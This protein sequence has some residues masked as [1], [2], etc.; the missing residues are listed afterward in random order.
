MG[1]VLSTKGR[2]VSRGIVSDKLLTGPVSDIMTTH[3]VYISPDATARAA[4]DLMLEER[5]GSLLVMAEDGLVAGVV[6][7][8]D[9]V[10]EGLHVGDAWVEASEDDGWAP[11]RWRS[12]RASQSGFHLDPSDTPLV[13]EVMTPFVRTVA[14]DETVLAAALQM[15]R[16]HVHYLVVTDRRTGHPVGMLSG[17]DVLRWLLEDSEFS[18]GASLEPAPGL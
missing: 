15:N 9:L 5:V 3:L 14:A 12:S 10:R 4:R 16:S 18:S 6:T 2:R 7:K 1:T 13:G 8:T 17:G 11:V